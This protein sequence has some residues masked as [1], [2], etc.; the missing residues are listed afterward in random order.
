MKIIKI[1]SICF[2]IIIML[3]Q[4]ILASELSEIFNNGKDFIST[5]QEHTNTTMN[6]E[7]VK[8][9]S[10]RIYNVLL[11]IATVVAVIVGAILGIQ[12][13]TAGISQKVE[14]KKSLFPY[15]I[16]CIVVFGSLGIWKLVVT[17]LKSF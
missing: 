1:L 3:S 5:G 17:I 4:N 9:L 15:F 8:T 14:V 13:M 16:S 6:T 11:I 7:K 2:C 10:N 12:F